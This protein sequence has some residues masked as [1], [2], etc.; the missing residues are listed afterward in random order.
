VGET[1]SKTFAIAVGLLG[2]AP[3]TGPAE[4]AEGALGVIVCVLASAGIEE[5]SV[6]FSV[7]CSWSDGTLAGGISFSAGEIVSVAFIPNIG[8]NE[9]EFGISGEYAVLEMLDEET[10]AAGVF[11]PELLLTGGSLPKKD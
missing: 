4:A 10:G 11:R 2:G 7:V 3:A 9:P 5:A 1:C 6:A 8:S